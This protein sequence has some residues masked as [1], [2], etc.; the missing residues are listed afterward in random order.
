MEENKTEMPTLTLNPF[1]ELQKEPQAPAV[2]GFT[3]A[4]GDA[5]APKE[6]PVFDDG[7]LTFGGNRRTAVGCGV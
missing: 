3:Q 6:E 2:P 7:T 5:L 1:E 4:D